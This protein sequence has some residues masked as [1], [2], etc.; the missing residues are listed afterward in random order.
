M[1]DVGTVHALLAATARELGQRVVAV[2]AILEEETT[3][4]V[5]L[6]KSSVPWAPG[7]EYRTLEVRLP[8]RLSKSANNRDL[9]RLDDEYRDWVR[10]T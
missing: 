7:H 6:I 4:R 2:S 3:D 9:Y 10:R 1:N 8:V 5:Y